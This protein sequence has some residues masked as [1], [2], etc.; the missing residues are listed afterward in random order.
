MII[1][2]YIE[3]LNTNFTIL[4]L[5]SN[6]NDFSQKDYICFDFVP[7]HHNIIRYRKGVAVIKDNFHT[8]CSWVQFKNQ[9]NWNYNLFLGLFSINII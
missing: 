4:I 8:V 1:F 7:K 9:E 6:L 5:I 3:I 2:F